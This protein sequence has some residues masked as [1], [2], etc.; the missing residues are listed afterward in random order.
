MPGMGYLIRRL[1]ENTSNDGFLKQ[2]FSD[3]STRDRLLS[4]PSLDRPPS[5]PLPCRHYENSNPEEPMTVF[6]NASHT[7]FTIADDR[8]KMRVAIDCVRR[9]FGKDYPLVIGSEA[10][11]TESTFDSINPS[12]K[13][14]IV[15]PMSYS[16]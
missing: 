9:D 5:T 8:E 4:D 16:L 7:N 3:R 13:T 6:K 15:V 14:E 11:A 12:N 2:S 1:L 10:V